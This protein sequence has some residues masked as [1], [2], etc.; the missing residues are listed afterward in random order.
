MTTNFKSLLSQQ[1]DSVEPPK[2]FPAAAYESVIVDHEF[3]ESSQKGTPYVRF[4][5]KLINPVGEFDQDAFDEAGGM[6][7]LSARNPLRYDFYLTDDAFFRLKNFLKDGL[8]LETSG[9][10]FDQLLPE[11]KN[12]GFVANVTHRA[13]REA[14]SMFMEINGYAA[15]AE[16]E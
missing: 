15:E 2:L 6:E 4:H 9:R 11:T 16:E 12:M 14:G 7:K 1:V 5:V 8:K 13:G 3:G 10:N